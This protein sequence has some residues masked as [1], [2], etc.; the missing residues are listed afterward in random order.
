MKFITKA[1]VAVGLATSL[2][3]ASAAAL[4]NDKI[5]VGMPEEMFLNLVEFVAQEKGFYEEQNLEVELVHIADSSIPVRALFAG[6]LDVSQAGMP[7]T[8]S[9][10]DKGA[11]LVTIGGVH[12]GLHYTFYVNPDANIETLEDLQGKKLGIS[13]PG[14]LPHVVMVAMMKEAGMTPEQIEDVTWVSLQGSSS[15]RNGIVTGIID[16]TVAG[17]NPRAVEDPSIGTAFNVPETLPNYVMT[18][19][20]TSTR[21]L[22]ENRDVLKRFIT[23]ELLATRWVLDNRDEAL[24]VAK[25]RFDYNEDELVAFYD[26][27]AER[28]WNP[29]G[30]VTPE[31]ADYMQQLNL[32]AGL[33]DNIHPTEKVLD[34][35]LVE[36]V[37]AEIGEY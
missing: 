4:S 20:D 32:E 7:E 25:T 2:M 13:G 27:Y 8:L 28:I 10:I 17:F 16:A 1:M 24:E 5:R 19:W 29:N 35:S 33:Q 31:Q 15:R 21:Y 9:A 6:E 22:E 30:T 37:L 34:T 12:T 11:G 26:F 14:T 18:P 23:A 3:S 36:E